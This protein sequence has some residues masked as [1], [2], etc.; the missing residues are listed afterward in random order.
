MSKSQCVNCSEV[1][2]P[3]KR[4][5]YELQESSQVHSML[6]G[7]TNRLQLRRRGKDSALD[8]SC[9]EQLEIFFVISSDSTNKSCASFLKN[10]WFHLL[11]RQYILEEKLSLQLRSILKIIA[12][13]VSFEPSSQT[14]VVIDVTEYYAEKNPG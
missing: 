13:L 10:F 3:R 4:D 14:V 7:L 1:T 11:R 6:M 2:L 12:Y 8:V 9:F 5:P